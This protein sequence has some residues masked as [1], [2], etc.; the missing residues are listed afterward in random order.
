MVGSF[1]DI[2]ITSFHAAHIV[3]MGVGGSLA[4]G[5]SI[6]QGLTGL[7]TLA[8]SSVVAAAG[9]LVGA[10]LGFRHN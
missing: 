6:G 3:S 8:L 10:R 5:C 7:S 2:S 4:L 9:I 1:G